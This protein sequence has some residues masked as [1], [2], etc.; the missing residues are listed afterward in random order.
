MATSNVMVRVAGEGGEGV[1]SVAEILTRS[2]ANTNYRVFTFRSYPAEIKGGLA[3]MQV[4]INTKAIGSI[5][6][7]A[8]VLM[9]FN[10]EAFDTWGQNITGRGVVLYDPKQCEIPEGFEHKTIAVPL[11]DTAMH[12]TGGRLPISGNFCLTIRL[13]LPI[14]RT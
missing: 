10:Q 8:D 6:M 14:L 13:L 1:I 9:A 12:E 7:D 4:R 2:A 5:E 11:H 3:M